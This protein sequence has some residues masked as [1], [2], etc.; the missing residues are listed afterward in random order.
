M[1]LL[2]TK[3]LLIP[4]LQLTQNETDMVILHIH[5]EGLIQSDSH[6]F[7]LELFDYKN[8]ES[9]LTAM[10]R[11]T[12]FSAA[13]IARFIW[14]TNQIKPS[15]C[16]LTDCYSEELFNYLFSNLKNAGMT[17]N[18]NFSNEIKNVN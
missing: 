17:I 13:L 1:M 2:F 18:I 12:G 14:N 6:K 8:Y 3:K 11:V 15:E 7:R 16:M 5:A 10:A 9:G 4:K